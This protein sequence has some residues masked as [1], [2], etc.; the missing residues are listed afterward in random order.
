MSHNLRD[1]DKSIPWMLIA[2]IVIPF[3]LVVI[4][5][6]GLWSLILPAVFAA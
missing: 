1:P 6:W 3:I 2:C 5:Q 4:A